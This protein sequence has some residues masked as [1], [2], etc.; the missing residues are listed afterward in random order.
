MFK[1]PPP[2]A[3]VISPV[4]E[5][6]SEPLVPLSHLGLDL[7]VPPIGWTGY[8]NNIGVEIVEDGIGRGAVSAADARMLI[9]EHRADEVRKAEVRAAAEKRAIEADQQWR[10]SLGHGV[11]V[12]DGVT[13][14]EAAQSAELDSL[15]YRPRASVVED[16]L[17]NDGMTFH[18]VRHEADES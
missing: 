3:E 6:T 10:A 13:Y 17:S 7:P 11:K 12:P 16:L 1:T 8:L 14:A 9:A 18:P 5:R 15:T 2:D 4:G